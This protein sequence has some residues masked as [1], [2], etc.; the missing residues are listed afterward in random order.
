MINGTHQKS[1]IQI[2]QLISPE[3]QMYFHENIP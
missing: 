2:A 1:G 3:A